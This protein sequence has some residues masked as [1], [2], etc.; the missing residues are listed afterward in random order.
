MRSYLRYDPKTGIGQYVW[1]ATLG[2]GLIGD[3]GFKSQSRAVDN[4]KPGRD[5]DSVIAE[6]QMSVYTAREL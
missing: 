2:K 1:E 5:D 6:C 3:D 4:T